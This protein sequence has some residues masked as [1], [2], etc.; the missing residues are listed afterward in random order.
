MLKQTAYQSLGTT[1]ITAKISTENQGSIQLFTTQLGFV[2]IGYS[3]I[4]GEVTLERVLSVTTSTTTKVE[5]ERKD[6]VTQAQFQ[7]LQLDTGDLDS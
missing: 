4:F 6:D 1:R 5:G 7:T 3:E 2:Q